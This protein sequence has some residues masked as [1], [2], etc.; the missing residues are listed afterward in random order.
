MHS[1]Y[2]SLNRNGKLLLISNLKDGV[3]EYQFSSMKKV[4]KFT[5]PVDINCIL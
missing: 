1:G 2:I 5:H 4:Q 3:D